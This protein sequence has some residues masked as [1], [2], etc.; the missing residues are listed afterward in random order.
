[1]YCSNFWICKSC[2]WKTFS[3]WSIPAPSVTSNLCAT[4]FC[5]SHY[6]FTNSDTKPDKPDTESKK[7]KKDKTDAKEPDGTVALG[8]E[9]MYSYLYC[10][11]MAYV[12]RLLRHF[13]IFL[14]AFLHV[15]SF[16]G[17]YC[18]C[19]MPWLATAAC[20]HAQSFCSSRSFGSDMRVPC[21]PIF[22]LPSFVLPTTSLPAQVRNLTSLT[23]RATKA[24]MALEVPWQ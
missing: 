9:T 2:L 15:L 11:L 14:F 19:L 8:Q 18:E 7:G 4:N 12:E 10:F 1:M 21:C 24:K 16:I 17:L 6:F 3:T 22:V 5:P 23:R 20:W 13:F